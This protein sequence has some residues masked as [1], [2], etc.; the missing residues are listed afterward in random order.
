MSDQG[1]QDT[2][3]VKIWHLE[4]GWGTIALDHTD[5]TVWV[6]FSHIVAGPTEYRSLT[7]GQRVRCHYEVPGQ[8]GYPA[9][10]VEVATL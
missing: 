6:H 10:A 7:P 9:R 3:V 2:G 5:L 4:E 8:D 1:L